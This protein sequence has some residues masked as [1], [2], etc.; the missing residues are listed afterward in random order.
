MYPLI[1]DTSNAGSTGLD[2]VV[3]ILGVRGGDVLNPPGRHEVAQGVGIDFTPY[4]RQQ[5]VR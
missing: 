5:Q 2:K 4:G 1:T 3:P